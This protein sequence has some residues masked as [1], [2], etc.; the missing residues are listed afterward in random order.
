MICYRFGRSADRTY[1]KTWGS[2]F[3]RL[4][5]VID[6]LVRLVPG[7]LLDPC[8]FDCLFENVVGAV[9]CFGVFSIWSNIATQI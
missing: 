4:C 5:E 2:G 6:D 8:L 1:A 7:I 9:C 3:M